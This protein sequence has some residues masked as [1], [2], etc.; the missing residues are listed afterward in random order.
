MLMLCLVCAVAGP[1][2]PGAGDVS[3]MDPTMAYG[4]APNMIVFAPDGGAGLGQ[5]SFVE[6]LTSWN[7]TIAGPLGTSGAQNVILPNPKGPMAVRATPLGRN[8]GVGLGQDSFVEFLTS[9]N[10]TIAGPLGTSGA[11]ENCATDYGLNNG[12][13]GEKKGSWRWGVLPMI[14]VVTHLGDLP[15]MRR[16]F[17]GSGYGIPI[18]RYLWASFILLICVPTTAAVTCRT[19]F[20]QIQGCT[21]GDDCP[22]VATTT[23]NGLLLGGLAAAT[24]TAIVARDVFPLRFTRVLTR[25][26]LD[27]LLII[28]RRPPPGTAVDV[29]ALTNVELTDPVRTSGVELEALLDEVTKRLGAATS[30]IELQRL[31]SISTAI[32]HKIKLGRGADGA[33][34]VGDGTEELVGVFRYCAMLAGKV[35]RTRLSQV[36]TVITPPQGDAQVKAVPPEKLMKPKNM[37]EFAD[38]LVT[39]TM[40]LSGLGLASILVSGAFL[41]EVVFDTIADGTLPWEGAYE[42]WLVY[43]EEVERTAGDDVNLSNVY[44]RGAQDTMIKRAMERLPNAGKRIFRPGGGG[45][46]GDGDEEP[47]WNGSFNQKSTATCLTFNLG[48]KQHPANCL[49][50]RGGCKF[51]HACDAY[52]SDQGKGGRCGSVKHGRHNCDNPAKV[53]KEQQ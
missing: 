30:N 48:K 44:N 21:G 4:A 3:T 19:C 27:S 15:T 41:R 42:L 49:N 9:W 7:T 39:W 51:N 45:G 53:S 6:F 46:D 37:A 26:V 43:L 24:A 32:G 20:D 5:D 29:S 12:Q 36:A 13:E 18:N 52:V 17:G 2:M 28:G 38:I 16:W 8:G 33:I 35:V 34:A 50:E 11:H 22:F 23:Q 10:T 14:V 1:V 47:K 25:G 40:L 31:N